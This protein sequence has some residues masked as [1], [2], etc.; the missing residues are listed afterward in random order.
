MLDRLRRLSAKLLIIAF[1]TV[2]L[3]APAEAQQNGAKQDGLQQ[4][5]DRAAK[6]PG[7][8]PQSS[9]PSDTA[10]ADDSSPDGKAIDFTDP[11]RRQQYVRLQAFG[12]ESI[13]TILDD[14]EWSAEQFL[15]AESILRDI[16]RKTLSEERP[17]R[18]LL[19][20]LARVVQ[21]AKKKIV[22]RM[23]LRV[24]GEFTTP[25]ALRYLSAKLKEPEFASAAIEA[26]TGHASTG[27]GDLLIDAWRDGF[28]DDHELAVIRAVGLRHEVEAIPLLA[29]RLRHSDS[30][31]VRASIVSLSRMAAIEAARALFD[32]ANDKESE[33]NFSAIMAIRSVGH[34]LERMQNLQGARTLYREVHE[35]VPTQQ[36]IG[37]A[38]MGLR[39][40][41]SAEDLPFF[42]EQVRGGLEGSARDGAILAAIDL[43]QRVPIV[44]H[45]E[46]YRELYTLFLDQ[47]RSESLYSK[48]LRS[49]LRL[50]DPSPQLTHADDGVF[51]NFWIFGALRPDFATASNP[52]T[53]EE[54]QRFVSWWSEPLAPEFGVD[55]FDRRVLDKRSIEWVWMDANPD[56]NHFQLDRWVTPG[57]FSV[58][59]LYAEFDV[60]EG[61][62]AILITG[63]EDSIQA[64]IN[65]QP[66]LSVVQDRDFKPDTDVTSVVLKKGPNRVLIKAAKLGGRWKV[67]ARLVDTDGNPLPFV[68]R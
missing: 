27:A 15:A 24:M 63:S 46:Q 58:A 35:N 22:R 13:C 14:G 62:P 26:M 48:V 36:G 10:A 43:P 20:G 49:R 52:S 4:S 7:S 31:I 32:I 29:E 57:S 67:A 56:E 61:G 6:S 9:K 53:E 44:E 34:Y 21:G 5:G 25:K 59:Y 50:A 3:I 11:E 28:L 51:R 55:L 47:M 19:Q 54:I 41:A 16:A 17:Q 37:L 42:I 8:T 1:A 23:A 38:W 12:A 65:D 68:I 64:W 66:V 39:T 60:E 30:D 33:H 45:L 18:T 40:T 2:S